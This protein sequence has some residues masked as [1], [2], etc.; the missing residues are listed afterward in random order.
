MTLPARRTAMALVTAASLGGCHTLESA[1]DAAEETLRVL[2]KGGS[3]GS[4]LDV[5]M[6]ALVLAAASAGA[7]VGAAVGAPQDLND[8]GDFVQH[9]CDKCWAWVSP[10]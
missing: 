10:P 5:V 8:L 4:P 1:S 3:S 7:V 9:Q 2:D 6:V